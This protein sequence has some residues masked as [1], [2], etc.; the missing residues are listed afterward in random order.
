MVAIFPE[1]LH[2]TSLVNITGITP[3]TVQSLTGEGL[4][5]TWEINKSNS[6]EPDNGTLTVYNL[7]TAARK[8]LASIVPSLPAFGFR[9]SLSIGWGDAQNPGLGF[10]PPTQVLSG[11]IVSITPEFKE[12]VDVLTE[13][14]FG[15]GVVEQRDAAPTGDV[16][17]FAK[18]LT[19]S[20]IVR[21]IVLELGLA[22]S[23]AADP[24]IDAAAFALG[25]PSYGAANAILGDR[26]IREKLDNI[27][28][29]LRIGYTIDD[30]IVRVFNP[31][32]LRNDLPPQEL[33]PRSGLLSFANTDDGGIEFEALANPLVAP[34]SQVVIRNENEI[35][36]GG[37]PLRVEKIQFIGDNY[38]DSIMTGVAR[39]FRPV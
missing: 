11:R 13:I 37:G 9:C 26:E 34:G 35:I 20:S 25:L 22:L 36:Q 4:R 24:V 29:T 12:R 27:F 14:T 5:V 19:W 16:Q 31:S 8:I 30:G 6:S 1:F 23:P 21:L 7:Q 32:G 10:V 38:A 18:L 39:K 17:K 15:D 2:V 33:A 28:E 3:I